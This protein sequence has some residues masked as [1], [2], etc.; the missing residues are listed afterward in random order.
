MAQSPSGSS[1]AARLCRCLP[2]VFTAQ[3][4]RARS[5]A[6]GLHCF[7]QCQSLHLRSGKPMSASVGHLGASAARAN[8]GVAEQIVVNRDLPWANTWATLL[9]T[10]SGLW[11]FLL[12]HKRLRPFLFWIDFLAKAQARACFRVF[13]DPVSRPWP[14]RWRRAVWWCCV[15]FGWNA[16]KPA[17]ASALGTFFPMLVALGVM[18]MNPP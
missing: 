1:P 17:A 9:P 10:L 14:L 6:R 13:C 15:G 8:R 2:A 11:P 5:Y 16:K 4:A 3:C 12:T 7:S 18:A